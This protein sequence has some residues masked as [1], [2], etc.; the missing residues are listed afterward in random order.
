MLFSEKVLL[1]VS[2]VTF[3][4]TALFIASATSFERLMFLAHT[5]VKSNNKVRNTILK[6]KAT[7]F[8]IIVK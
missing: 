5:K 4:T 2:G 8:Q 6:A 3:S 7:E 1:Y